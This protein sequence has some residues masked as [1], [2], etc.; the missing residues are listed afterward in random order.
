[1]SAILRPFLVCIHDATPAFARETE[2]MLR[3]L[4]PLVGRCFSMAVVPDWRGAWP[5]AAHPGYCRMVAGAAGELLLHGYRHHR[6]HGAGPVTWL[7]ERSDEMRGLDIPQTRRTIESGQRIFADAF[8]APARGFVPPAWQRGKV[9]RGS[10]RTFGLDY[11]VD[12]FSLEAC[13]GERV[14]LATS[15]WDCGRWGW[16]GHIGHGLGRVLRAADRRVPVLALHP[17]DVARGFW[18]Q[19]LRLTGSLLERGYQP[20]TST[21]ILERNHA[22]IAA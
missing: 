13:T 17:R 20:A 6:R 18:P 1:M 15:S 22:A 12:F 16:L 7:A 10:G 8:G 19:I 3:D 2:L 14:P 4:A 9:C 21:G 11:V 5:L